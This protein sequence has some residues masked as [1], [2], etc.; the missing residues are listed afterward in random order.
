M[1]SPKSAKE[2]CA[3]VATLV[4]T[5]PLPADAV[6]ARG[7]LYFCSGRRC[8]WAC[9]GGSGACDE[10]RGV[11]LVDLSGTSCQFAATGRTYCEL[12]SRTRTHGLDGARFVR[13]VSD[14]IKGASPRERAALVFFLR[15]SDFGLRSAHGVG[16]RSPSVASHVCGFLSKRADERGRTLGDDGDSEDGEDDDDSENDSDDDEAFGDDV[17]LAKRRP[18]RGAGL[19]DVAALASTC[20]LARAFVGSTLEACGRRT[21]DAVLLALATASNRSRAKYEACR[22]YRALLRRPAPSAAAFY[23]SRSGQDKGDSTSLQREC[24]ARARS[25]K[26]IHA[27]RPF[28]EMIARPKISRNEWKTAEI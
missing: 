26:H 14:A 15:G 11:V 22:S 24:S 28:R 1:L 21:V 17:E 19:R 4:E 16:P 6:P 27:S 18:G 7:G 8:V 13:I 10:L 2:R 12:A 23:A 9:G 3:S 20:R 25:G 5:R